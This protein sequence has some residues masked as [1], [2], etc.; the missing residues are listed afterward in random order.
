MA[1]FEIW[2]EIT[3]ESTDLDGARHSATSG[4]D[5]NTAPANHVINQNTVKVE[6]ASQNGSENSYDL[7]YEG[8]VEIVPGTLLK[9]PTT[10]KVRTYAR[11]PKGKFGVGRG[12]SK[13]KVTGEYVKYK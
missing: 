13:I 12:W 3:T 11:S 7:I 6:W 9:F 2:S 4:W 5:T 8:W 1:G 10:I